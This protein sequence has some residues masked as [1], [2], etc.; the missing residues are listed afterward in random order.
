MQQRLPVAVH[1]RNDVGHILQVARCRDCLLQIFCIPLFHAVLVCRIADDFFLLCRC[2]LSG[3]DTQ[4]HAILFPKVAQD[5]LLIR[6]SR[7][8]PECPDTAER[9]SAD[10]MIRVKLDDGRCDHVKKT[11]KPLFPR[12]LCL[13]FFLS[14]VIHLK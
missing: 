13:C 6:C 7:I 9:I 4:C 1:G 2:D 10:I 8:F 14:V 12:C 11:L 5:C 3:I